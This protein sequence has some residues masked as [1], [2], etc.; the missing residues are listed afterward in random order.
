M[1]TEFNILSGECS[2]FAGRSNRF[3]V[4]EFR[5]L[6]RRSSWGWWRRQFASLEAVRFVSSVAEWFSLR[7]TTPTKSYIFLA[8]RIELVPKVIDDRHG[9]GNQKGTIFPSSNRNF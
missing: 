2:A 7:I 9:T 8:G 3:I 1:R 4:I 6:L 5:L